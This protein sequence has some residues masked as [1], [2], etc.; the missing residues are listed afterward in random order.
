[1]PFYHVKATILNHVANAEQI[2]KGAMEGRNI[3]PY[4]ETHYHGG[5]VEMSEEQAK[6]HLDTGM[7]E[8][9]VEPPVDEKA[10]APPAKSSSAS[11]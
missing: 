4:V 1:M 5:T 9:P 11:K 7:L 10:D 8:G 6:R 2:V 3:L